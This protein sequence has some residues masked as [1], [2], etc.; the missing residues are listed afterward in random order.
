MYSQQCLKLKLCI[1]TTIM[2]TVDFIG[3]ESLTVNDCTL[4]MDVYRRGLEADWKLILLK[5][6]KSSK[7]SI[8]GVAWRRVETDPHN[9]SK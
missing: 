7:E 1:L 8:N 5:T 3:I 4:A 2:A 9:H 6:V